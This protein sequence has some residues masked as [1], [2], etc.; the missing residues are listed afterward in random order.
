MCSLTEAAG[1]HRPTHAVSINVSTGLST[2][3]PSAGAANLATE[4]KSVSSLGSGRAGVG[5]A[6]AAAEDVGEA[7]QRS[8]VLSSR[9]RDPGSA[10]ETPTGLQAR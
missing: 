3:M 8:S 2:K 4:R 9:L 7:A 10:A 6:S 5:L 1:A